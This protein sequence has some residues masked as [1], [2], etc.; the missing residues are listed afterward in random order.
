MVLQVKHAEQRVLPVF[1]RL[2][3]SQRLATRAA[4]IDLLKNMTREDIA[5]TDE[6]MR[7]EQIYSW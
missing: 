5:F 4:A 6:S 3:K 1:V 7:I 2:L